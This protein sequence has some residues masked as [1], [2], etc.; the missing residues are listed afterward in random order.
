MIEMSR[1]W[2]THVI[3]ETSVEDQRNS[4]LYECKS[5][6]GWNIICIYT[7]IYG[8]SAFCFLKSE[9]VGFPSD[10][11]WNRHTLQPPS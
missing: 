3:S 5:E 11:A 4:C 6:N 8:I 10:K 2:P 1:N 9:T 7:L